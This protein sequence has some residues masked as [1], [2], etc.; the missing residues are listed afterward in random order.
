LKK[1][2]KEKG[3]PVGKREEF[4]YSLKLESALKGPL[5]LDFHYD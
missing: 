3:K 2:K 5:F 1:K 4:V